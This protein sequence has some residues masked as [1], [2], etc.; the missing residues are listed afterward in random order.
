MA[1]EDLKLRRCIGIEPGSSP[2]VFDP[3]ADADA[4]PDAC[5][6]G[7]P[8]GFIV[9]REACRF[10]GFVGWEQCPFATFCGFCGQPPVSEAK[11]AHAKDRP[12]AE[13]FFCS[14]EL[15][16]CSASTDLNACAG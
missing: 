5:G 1:W 7:W 10:V 9:R 13:R 11:G 8:G 15:A 14:N 16:V 4:D 6:E 12:S 2:S 3:D